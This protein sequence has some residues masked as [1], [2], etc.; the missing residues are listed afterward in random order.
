[1]NAIENKI[2]NGLENFLSLIRE[3]EEI[4][5]MSCEE[6]QEQN[7][8][9]QDLL[10]YIELEHY[11]YHKCARLTK[12]LREVRRKRRIA[13]DNQDLVASLVEWAETN[14]NIIKTLERVL[15]ESR[16]KERHIENRFYIPRAKEIADGS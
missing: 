3:A 12:N 6:E 8:K 5:R 4:N 10:H 2:S 9:Q 13:K 16:K 15:G 7:N 14:K 1:M 11:D